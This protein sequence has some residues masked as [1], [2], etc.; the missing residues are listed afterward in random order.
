MYIV[1]NVQCHIQLLSI[2]MSCLAHAEASS[3]GV[4]F[5]QADYTVAEDNSSI[6]VTG[7]LTGLT[8]ELQTSFS[9]TLSTDFGVDSLTG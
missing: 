1:F 7:R 3:V 9:L 8:G 5:D 6:M 2:L 4:S